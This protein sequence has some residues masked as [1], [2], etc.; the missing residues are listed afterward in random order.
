VPQV[1]S[2]GRHS[3]GGTKRI[4]ANVVL[5]WFKGLAGICPQCFVDERLVES[6]SRAS[7]NEIG[8][9][10]FCLLQQ[11]MRRCRKATAVAFHII[12]E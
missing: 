8:S 12:Q 10:L 7:N 4:I 11:T 1:A 6:S 2:D 5:V 9:R 3:G